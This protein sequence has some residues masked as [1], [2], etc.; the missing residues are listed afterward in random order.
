M[1]FRHHLLPEQ[2][3]MILTV[4]SVPSLMR[5]EGRH[6]KRRLF[7]NILLTLPNPIGAIRN[8]RDRLV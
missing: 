8:A 6:L 7:Q 5:P 3:R 4:P 1:N 2:R